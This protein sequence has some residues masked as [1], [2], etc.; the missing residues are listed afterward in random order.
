MVLKVTLVQFN[1]ISCH[2]PRIFHDGYPSC[3]A[4]SPVGRRCFMVAATAGAIVH[5]VM[6][7]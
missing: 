3:V 1:E 4:A 5:A 2:E 7:Q 6:F